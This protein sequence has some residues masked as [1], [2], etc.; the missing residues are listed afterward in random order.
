MSVF[1]GARRR[2]F[3]G[4]RWGAD[5]REDSNKRLDLEKAQYKGWP[6]RTEAQTGGT[7]LILKNTSFKQLTKADTAR[8]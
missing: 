5:V 6:G 3:E 1:P 4:A 2:V 8:E 7:L